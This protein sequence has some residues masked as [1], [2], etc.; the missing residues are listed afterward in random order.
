MPLVK[1]MFPPAQLGFELLAQNKVALMDSD[2]LQL[3]P[4]ALAWP[5]GVQPVFLAVYG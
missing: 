1:D 3:S 5:Q 4:H 2:G